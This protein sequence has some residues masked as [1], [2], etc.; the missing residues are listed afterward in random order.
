[1]S[2]NQTD[3]TPAQNK[4]DAVDA[5]AAEIAKREGRSQISDADRKSAFEEMKETSP[6]AAEEAKADE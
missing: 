5:R 4:T 3:E 2:Q 1:M 6:P